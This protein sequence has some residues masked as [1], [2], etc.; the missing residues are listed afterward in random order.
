MSPRIPS[1]PPPKRVSP[2]PSP[3]EMPE[4]AAA[5][6]AQPAADRFLAQPPQAAASPPLQNEPLLHRGAA[7]QPGA[8]GA[9]ASRPPRDLVLPW[10]LRGK[11]APSEKSLLKLNGGRGALF[12]VGEWKPGARPLVLVHGIDADFADLQPIIDRFRNDPSHQLLVY[13]YDDEDRYTGDNGVDLGHELR[14]LRER[15]PWTGQLDIVAHSMG[16][17]IARRGLDELAAGPQG[18]IDKFER[19]RLVAVDTPWHGFP[20]PGWRLP[21][22]RGAMDMQA[23]GDLFQGSADAKDE[24]SRKGLLGVALPSNVEVQIVSADNVAAGGKPD[25]ILDYAD[26]GS[27]AF[28][29]DLSHLAEAMHRYLRADPKERSS[30]QWASGLDVYAVNYLK[31]LTSDADW[32]AA[33][34]ELQDLWDQEK[35]QPEW[36]GRVLARHMPRYA[37]EHTGVLSNADLLRDLQKML[38]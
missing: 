38:D 5:A 24:A 8:W 31:A 21:F 6:I 14:A 33:E 25:A 13:A 35:L 28:G 30:G 1:S 34:A 3:K 7:V 2:A 17:I 32:P 23:R 15:Y 26:T 18:G 11:S 27:N 36:I 12:A 20:G 4:P 9:E 22:Y 29:A 16:G 10:D 37:G 19:V